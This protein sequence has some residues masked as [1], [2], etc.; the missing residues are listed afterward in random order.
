[1][2]VSILKLPNGCI[3]FFLLN[4]CLSELACPNILPLLLIQYSL[5]FDVC[6]CISICLYIKTYDDILRA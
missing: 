3:S 2:L 5:A 4:S 6:I 1:M